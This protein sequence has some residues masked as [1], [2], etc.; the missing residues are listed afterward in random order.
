LAGEGWMMNE[1]LSLSESERQLLELRLRRAREGSR[2]AAIRPRPAGGPA[3]L[4]FAQERLWFLY[5]WEPDLPVYNIP[6]AFQIIGPLD[7]GALLAAFNSILQRHEILRTVYRLDESVPVPMV[8]N[9][10]LPFHQV[11][12]NSI[13]SAVREVEVHHWTETEARRPFDLESELPIRVV[14]LQLAD[15]EHILLW[16]M[17]H[18][19]TDGW[20]NEV[21]FRELEVLYGGLCAGQSPTLPVPPLQYADFAYWQRQWLQGETL[22]RQLTYWK[23]H[24]G[25]AP[26]VLDLP[27]TRSRPPIRTLWGMVQH[28]DFASTLIQAVRKYSEVEGVTPFMVYLCAFLILLYRYTGRDDLVVGTPVAGRNRSEVEGLVGC[29][30]NTLVLR[31]GLEGNPR[32]G[33]LVKRVREVTLN[34]QA[35]QELPFEKLVEALQPERHLSHSPLF[36][37]M[38]V[39]NNAQEATL[40]L[41]GLTVNSLE[42]ESATSKFDLSWTVDDAGERVTG[43]VTYDTDL[44]EAESILR[45]LGHYQII[46]ETLTANPALRVSDLS[47][48]TA[49]EQHQLLVEWNQTHVEYPRSQGLSQLVEAQAARSPEA[50]ALVFPDGDGSFQITY[51]HLNAKANQLAYYLR[52][53]GVGPDRRVGVCLERSGEMVVALLAV[54]KAGGAYVP[55]DPAYPVERLAFLLDDS[56]A[57]VLLTHSHLLERLAG[58]GSGGRVAREHTSPFLT[59]CL[60]TEWETINQQSSIP[61]GLSVS[62]PQFTISPDN[63]AYII[64]TSGSTGQPKGAINTHRGIIN[65]LQWM[66]A[67]YPLTAQDGVL[68]KTPFGF[69]VSVWE[70]FGPLIAGARLIIAQPGGQRDSAYLKRLIAEQYIT[71]LHFVPAMLQV[72]LHEPDLESDCTSLRRV[73]CGGEA[74]SAELQT[75][76]MARLKASLYNL[77]GPAEAAIDVTAWP[78]Q[79]VSANEM[80]PIGWPIANLQTY[81]LDCDLQPVPIGIPGE[82]YVGGIGLARGYLGRPELTAEKFIPN[83]FAEIQAKGQ[84]QRPKGQ[85]PLSLALNPW[86]LRLY[87]TGDL[88]RY[89]S[90]GAIEFLGRIDFQVKIHGYRIEPGEIEAALVKHSAIREALVIAQEDKTEDRR[91]VAY[92]IPHDSGRLPSAPELRTFLQQALPE[93]LIP[94]FSVWLKAWPLNPNGKIDRQALPVPEVAP[95]LTREAPQPPCTELERALAGIWEELLGVQGVGRHTNFFEIGGNSIKG[96]LFTNRLQQILGRVVRVITIFDAP[97][98]AELAVYLRQQYPEEVAARW[99]EVSLKSDTAK[100]ESVSDGASLAPILTASRAHSL[101]LSF[102]Q[103]RLWFLDQLAPEQAVYNVS[104]WTQFRGSLQLEALERSLNDFVRRHEVLRTTFPMQAGIP[105]QVIA[106]ELALRLS[107]VDVSALPESKRYHEWHR[108]AQAEAWRPFDLAHGPLLRVQLI[109]LQPHDHVLVL[110]MHHIISDGWSVEILR[111][112]LVAFYEAHLTGGRHSLSALPIQYADYAVWQREWLQGVVLDEQLAY[113]KQRLAG[114]PPSLELPLDHPRPPVQTYRGA[115]VR[116]TFSAGLTGNLRTLAQSGGLTLH[117]VLLAGFMALL[118]RYTGQTDIL[119]G[120]PVAGRTRAEIEALIGCFVNTLV[121]RADLAGD[122]SFQAL[123]DQVRMV[124]LEAYAHADL[125]FEKLV[126]ELRPTRDLSRNP[127][128]QV[129]FV[130]QNAPTVS[131]ITADLTW[132]PLEVS[133]GPAKF[134]L[135]LFGLDAGSALEVFLEYNAD[136]FERETAEQFVRHFEKLLAEATTSPAMRLSALPLLEV[137]E[138]AALLTKWSAQ[139]VDYP[140]EHCLHEWFNLQANAQPEAVAVSCDGIHLTYH[141]VDQ[142]ANWLA[143]KLIAHGVRPE[144]RVGICLERQAELPIALLGVLKA[145][146][147]YVPL[148]PAYPVERLAYMAEDAGV[149]VVVT[150]RSLVARLEHVRGER[151]WIEEWGTSVSVPNGGPVDPANLAY[152]IYTS[153]STGRPK[154]VMVS[155]ANGVRLLEASSKD[156]GF[157]SNDVWTLFHSYA[158]D[159]S[160]W[161]VWGAWRYGG[162]LVGVPYWISRNPERFYTL[163]VEEGVTVLNQT[164][165]AFRQLS[166]LEGERGVDPGLK[167]KWLIFGGEA[168]E[169]STLT[170]WWK[171]HSEEQPS[172]INMYGITETTVHVTYRKLSRDDELAGR[173]SPIGAPLADLQ[174]YVLDEG[175]EPVPSGIAGELYVGG[176]GLARGYLGRPELTAERFIPNPFAMRDEGRTTGDRFARR[177]TN[178]GD[179]PPSSVLRLYKTG[180]RA[181]WS[182]DGTLEYL[183]RLDHQVKVRGFRIEL[184]EIEAVLSAHPDVKECVVVARERASETQLVAYVVGRQGIEAGQLRHSLREHLPEYMVPIIV[185]LPNLPLTANGKVDRRNLPEVEEVP[186][187]EPSV[188]PQTEL[189]RKVAEVWAEVL[190]RPPVGRYAD[191]FELGGNS[192]SAVRVVARLR[193]RLKVEVPLRSLFETGRLA[194]FAQT[195]EALVSQPAAETLASP[196][197]KIRRLSREPSA[198]GISSTSSVDQKR[199]TG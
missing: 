159:F 26:P 127:V 146:G 113:W 111:R 95:P 81:I 94:A 180:D 132:Q 116:R 169:V 115:T 79:P 191:F 156:F 64:Y 23:E 168:L 121:L 29:L 96:A 43:T 134:D 89:R 117:M 86:S 122:P 74:L 147:A 170:A 148:D 16:T 52:S 37:V 145:G 40:N 10:S 99:P 87:R 194:D 41:P 35:Y 155:H 58:M 72:F 49:T 140:V 198:G 11:D 179:R 42:T 80:V 109:Y 188:A 119:V 19:A 178:D 30:I 120:T 123:L 150:A 196:V 137:Q 44:F 110:T 138:R 50:I 78:C 62:N 190:G 172:L 98:I 14:L 107:H 97:T 114:C 104:V 20:S 66:Q 181:R 175:L 166:G 182:L 60:D 77:Y 139:T 171:R 128:F 93:Y 161:E 65:R 152:V 149:E 8:L 28:F 61:T 63:L 12:L 143:E 67:E 7:R 54:L 192:L 38:F 24:L 53:L 125:P 88:A 167:L 112:E 177:T 13:E 84:G 102:A 51:E 6:L 34:A 136:L 82:L 68:H 90:D 187:D 9:R 144:S 142:R 141:Q 55:L 83:P 73:F 18:I 3:C 33:E 174:L 164:P 1:E 186:R 32:L 75:C 70:L 69:D 157:T 108:L 130:L 183:G 124:C 39:F 197:P 151:I 85:E 105:R 46:L 193:E 48:L 184:G 36:Q 195:I 163:L 133:E 129:M 189:E 31:V 59:L 176:A 131:S 126:E 199:G 162:R 173:R 158:F 57:P 56:Q 4:S 5:Q 100:S 154:G 91:L 153:G 15:N 106:P 76:F 165:S 27:T 118:Q 2:V 22:D 47:C 45:W 160:V 21:L 135:T 17:H 25:S 185:L 103:E 92:L 71:T 101:P